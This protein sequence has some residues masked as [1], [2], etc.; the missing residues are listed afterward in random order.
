MANSK[1]AIPASLRRPL[2]RSRF[3][4]GLMSRAGRSLTEQSKLTEQSRTSK[5]LSESFF[6][7]MP[8][9]PEDAKLTGVTR[10]LHRR[11]LGLNLS[12]TL[13][14]GSLK[15]VTANW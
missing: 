15:P 5:A 14:K 12:G 11:L 10:S 4:E 7:R 8:Q 1:S 2:E 3:A 6:F 13:L 9:E